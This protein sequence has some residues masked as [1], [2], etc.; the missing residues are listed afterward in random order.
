VFL[1]K[2]F[3]LCVGKGICQSMYYDW[4]DK[5]GEVVPIDCNLTRYFVDVVRPKFSITTEIANKIWCVLRFF[6]DGNPVDIVQ[7]HYT[8]ILSRDTVYEDEYFMIST[9]VK[10]FSFKDD[11]FDDTKTFYDDFEFGSVAERAKF[12][13]SMLAAY[14]M[15]I[16]STIITS[17]RITSV[18]CDVPVV[19]DH[20]NVAILDFDDGDVI[21]EWGINSLIGDFASRED[22]WV[23][24]ELITL[25]DRHFSDAQI[26]DYYYRTE[27]YC[28]AGEDVLC[29]YYAILDALS[30]KFVSRYVLAFKDITDAKRFFIKLIRL[31][32]TVSDLVSI[33]KF[34]EILR[35]EGR[36]AL[37][38]I[39]HCLLDL[40]ILDLG[41]RFCDDFLVAVYWLQGLH[42][43]DNVISGTIYDE[44]GD[45]VSVLVVHGNED[46][47][48]DLGFISSGFKDVASYLDF[49]NVSH[50][51]RVFKPGKQKGSSVTILCNKKFDRLFSLK[52][53]NN[54]DDCFMYGKAV[55]EKW[56]TNEIAMRF[57]DVRPKKMPPVPTIGPILDG[58]AR[59]STS[60][61]AVMIESE[62]R[63]DM[64]GSH[65]CK[66]QFYSKRGLFQFALSN[67]T[68]K[69]YFVKQTTG[70]E[71]WKFGF[72]YL[73]QVIFIERVLLGSFLVV[74]FVIWIL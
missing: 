30:V 59:P 70:F 32:V 52:S 64:Y 58:V 22:K 18:V 37:T 27:S 63:H 35:L 23:F 8:A 24:L 55:Y 40:N 12:W 36:V 42:S 17:G 14:K 74:V 65:F 29:L 54:I 45:E 7:H 49:I 66:P 73:I 44:C 62:I 38:V 47:L 4:V 50:I 57:D 67:D 11:H 2:D 13:F 16:V 41:F 20:T 25:I 26:V 48:E 3:S 69:E 34:M 72:R 10:A 46:L 68:F 21:N 60:M 71:E 61:V 6:D 33:Y 51:G 5:Y 19:D 15:G 1:T 28:S 31:H 53:Y 56:F 43:A 9:M 39:P